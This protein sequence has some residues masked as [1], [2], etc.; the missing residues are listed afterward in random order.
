MGELMANSRNVIR[1]CRRQ[2]CRF[3]TVFLVARLMSHEFICCIYIGILLP[4]M[5]IE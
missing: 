3:R 5:H 2:C 1:V 4:L